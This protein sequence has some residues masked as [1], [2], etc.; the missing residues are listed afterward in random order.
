MDE[1][2]PSRRKLP[3]HWPIATVLEHN[4]RSIRDSSHWFRRR[5]SK[6]LAAKS[7]SESRHGARMRAESDRPHTF[8]QQQS[9]GGFFHA[10]VAAVVV[11]VFTFFHTISENRCIDGRVIVRLL[12][13]VVMRKS[14]R[15]SPH[16][17]DETH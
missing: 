16:G 5:D 14:P 10:V 15:V 13:A 9:S 2:I 7:A 1:E 6:L 12:A 4:H 8:D 17:V 3:R 11:V